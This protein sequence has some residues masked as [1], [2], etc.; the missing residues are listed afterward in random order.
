MV[1]WEILRG[2]MLVQVA[3]SD[4]G[5]VPA[6][7][8]DGLVLTGSDVVADMRNRVHVGDK[9]LL[10]DRERYLHENATAEA[11]FGYRADERNLLPT[12]GSVGPD[13]DPVLRELEA[14]EHA[15]AVLTPTGLIAAGDIRTLRR[16]LNLFARHR[17]DR[18]VLAL[19]L[20]T[21]WLRSAWFPDFKKLLLSTEGPKALSFQGRDDPFDEE[22]SVAKLADMLDGATD[23]GIV[24]TGLAGVGAFALGAAFT[25]IG[26]TADQRH[27]P[28]P[29]DTEPP[30]NLVL[31]RAFLSFHD[32]GD[33]NLALDPES[34]LAHCPCDVCG[35]DQPLNRFHGTDTKHADAHNLAVLKMLADELAEYPTRA[36]RTE[37]WLS[38]CEEAHARLEEL[39]ASQ[40]SRAQLE[41][42]PQLQQWAKLRS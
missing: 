25:A 13:T 10:G 5:L 40:V 36:H 3:A 21:G 23:L 2:T 15:A 41:I 20:G 24:R 37:W 7:R 29:A 42:P 27:I 38:E 17:D 33:L 32:A 31:V 18:L 26:L 28:V 8:L 35:P 19:P 34:D 6:N 4:M 22:Q 39:N 16:A 9:I 12:V 14:Q 30:K 1:G 11:P